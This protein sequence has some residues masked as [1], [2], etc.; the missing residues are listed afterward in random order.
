MLGKKETSLAELFQQA[1]CCYEQEE[2][3]KA[4]VFYTQIIEL[5][6]NYTYQLDGPHSSYHNR[7]LCYYQQENIELALS[8]FSKL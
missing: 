6:P 4:I 1:I 2:Y 7:G 8:D 5:E 3:E